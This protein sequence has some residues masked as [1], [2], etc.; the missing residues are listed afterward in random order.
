MSHANEPEALPYSSEVIFEHGKLVVRR[1]IIVDSFI[2]ARMRYA[3][4]YQY[5][6]QKQYDAHKRRPEDF[7]R[8]AN[9]TEWR[10]HEY[11]AKDDVISRIYDLIELNWLA[12]AMRGV[13]DPA[14]CQSPLGCTILFPSPELSARLT[15]KLWTILRSH[16]ASNKSDPAVQHRV[17]VEIFEMLLSLSLS[18]HREYFTTVAAI[19]LLCRGSFCNWW[20]HFKPMPDWHGG[21]GNAHEAPDTTDHSEKGPLEHLEK[22]R[23]EWDED[24]VTEDKSDKLHFAR[25]SSDF[26]H[27]HSIEQWHG[28]TYGIDLITDVLTLVE[29]EWWTRSCTPH[30]HYINLRLNQRGSGVSHV[31]LLVPSKD[32]D[33]DFI[34]KMIVALQVQEMPDSREDKHSEAYRSAL[35]TYIGKAIYTMHTCLSNFIEALVDTKSRLYYET[36]LSIWNTT[37]PYLIEACLFARL[38]RRETEI[39]LWTKHD[40]H[41]W[42]LPLPGPAVKSR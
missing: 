9:L 38:M 6:Q 33:T 8:R 2:N 13:T 18:F 31:L 40:R 37:D 10:E 14:A 19:W 27:F 30:R 34:S 26:F 12:E 24:S 42:V 4:E 23:Q 17:F 11:H 28:R 16:V 1:S 36:L 25:R 39:C 32:H 7:F 41:H 20:S 3:V 5:Q 21:T 15:E 29:A 35:L 22:L